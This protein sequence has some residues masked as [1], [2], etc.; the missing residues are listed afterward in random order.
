M[1]PVSIAICAR[2]GVGDSFLG[3]V[4]FARTRQPGAKCGQWQP[5]SDGRLAAGEMEE[6]L[7]ALQETSV[8]APSHVGICCLA[9]G[10]AVSGRSPDS[11]VRRRCQCEA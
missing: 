11:P 2:H 10:C 7:K 5:L 1:I 9:Y 4:P 8:G 6:L 3:T